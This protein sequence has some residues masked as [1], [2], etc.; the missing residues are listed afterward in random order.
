MSEKL[1]DY[2]LQQIRKKLPPKIQALKDKYPQTVYNVS[3]A[4]G[5]KPLPHGYIAEQIS[6]F[7]GDNPAGAD[8]SFF[9]GELIV[10]ELNLPKDKNVIKMSIDAD[11]AYIQVGKEV[12]LD[13]LGGVILP[14]ILLEQGRLLEFTLANYQL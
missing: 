12:L 7:Y 14:D 9:E 8:I 3:E 4:W 11:W 10:F 13:R 6:I 2:E 1:T 5:L